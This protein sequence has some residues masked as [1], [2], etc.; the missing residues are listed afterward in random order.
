MTVENA[1]I[2]LDG[3]L[4]GVTD[5]KGAVRGKLPM[6]SYPLEMKVNGISV[7]ENTLTLTSNTVNASLRFQYANYVKDGAINGKDYAYSLRCGFGDGDL[8]DYG[9]INADYNR[10]I[11]DEN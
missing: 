9:K 8:F 10:I 1:E 4:F 7:F 3:E 2:Y 5:S 11:Y 6:G